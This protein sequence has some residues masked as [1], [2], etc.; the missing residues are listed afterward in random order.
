[1]IEDIN[2][3]LDLKTPVICTLEELMEV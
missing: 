1:M 3:E 2:L